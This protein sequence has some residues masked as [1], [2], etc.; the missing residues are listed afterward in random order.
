MDFLSNNLN[1]EK[2]KELIDNSPALSQ[3]LTKMD[4]STDDIHPM[5]FSY[6]A[7]I[8]ALATEGL[9]N[10]PIG[11]M[12]DGIFTAAV[13]LAAPHVIFTQQ[14]TSPQSGFTVF[15]IADGV[16][17]QDL[18]GWFTRWLSN[19]NLDLTWASSTVTVA[20]SK[21]PGS[22]KLLASA[23]LSFA[24][25]ATLSAVATASENPFDLV[26]VGY[27]LFATAIGP[28]ATD[29][30]RLQ[31]SRALRKTPEPVKDM[32]D[33]RSIEPVKVLVQHPTGRIS[34][35]NITRGLLFVLL[36]QKQPKIFPCMDD[37]VVNIYKTIAWIV[38]ISQGVALG[39]S[40]LLYQLVVVA[41]TGLFALGA[42]YGIGEETAYIAGTDLKITTS[43]QEGSDTNRDAY[44]RL[45]LTDLEEERMRAWN[46]F[47]TAN[48]AWEE[49]YAASKERLVTDN[50]QGK[51]GIKVSVDKLEEGN[52]ERLAKEQK[53]KLEKE[54][55]ASPKEIKTGD[56]AEDKPPRP[57]RM[58]SERKAGVPSEE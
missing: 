48:E 18:A 55:G 40:S 1:I 28:L 16:V 50:V 38:V 12:T 15:N 52:Q 25:I 6:V 5:Q 51:A 46:L 43:R 11:R 4:R 13:P 39:F 24:T 58:T 26:H 34:R 37:A 56:E 14:A 49:R 54:T 35:L 19:P 3:L 20:V 8:L 10:G 27:T 42:Y 44:V 7:P 30:F 21:N 47:P 17:T 36:D 2:L 57:R 23:A 31:L 41:I 29:K 53:E 22:N 45:C 32:A 9:L 33:L